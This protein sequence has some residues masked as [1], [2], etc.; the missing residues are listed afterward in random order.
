MLPRWK[1]WQDCYMM[2]TFNFDYSNAGKNF[3]VMHALNAIKR[4]SRLTLSEYWLPNMPLFSP[5]IA[6]SMGYAGQPG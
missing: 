4:Q 5:A 3:Y 2:K 6:L 1:N